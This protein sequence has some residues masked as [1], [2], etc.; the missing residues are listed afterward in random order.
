MYVLLVEDNP[1]NA[2][3]M[4]RLLQSE[5]LTVTHFTKG[6]DAAK[7]ARENKPALVLLDFNLPDIDGLALVTVLKKQLRDNLPPFIAVTARSGRTEE[8]IAERMGFDAFISKPFEPE[9]FVEVI[10]Y[11]M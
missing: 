9:E 8:F 7:Y 5:D 10:R 6:M 4:I 1:D 3:M 2:N 11:F